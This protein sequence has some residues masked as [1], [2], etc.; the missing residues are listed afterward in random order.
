MPFRDENSIGEI[1][2][3]RWP[4]CVIFKSGKTIYNIKRKIFQKS[5]SNVVFLGLETN[6]LLKKKF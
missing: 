1:K 6:F 2:L 5:R 4:I 3:S